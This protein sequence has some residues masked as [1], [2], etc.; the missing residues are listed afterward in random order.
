M[1]TETE[2]D[3]TQTQAWTWNW[4]TFKK[5]LIRRNNPYSTIW[6]ASD[7][8]RRNFQWRYILLAPFH[9]KQK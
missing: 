1:E 7:I 8:S 2:I 6:I 4:R 3:N 5:Y 9:D